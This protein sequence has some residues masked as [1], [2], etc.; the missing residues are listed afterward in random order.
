MKQPIF[1]WE[2]EVMRKLIGSAGSLDQ[3]KKLIEKF[4]YSSNVTLHNDGK[5]STGRGV[6]DGVRWIE[7]SGRYRFER[8]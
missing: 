3:L 5:V 1:T 2:N 7:K 4:Y 6:I 8:V